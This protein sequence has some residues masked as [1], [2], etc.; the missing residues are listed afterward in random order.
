MAKKIG[1]V[2]ALDGEKQ[3][4][5]GLSNAKQ[6][7]ARL[8]AELK[9]L[10]AE[11]EGS[12][13]SLEYLQKKQENLAAQTTSYTQKLEASKKGLGNAQSVQKKAAE[14]YEELTKALEKAK[15][16]Q[17]AMA[18]A[19]ETNTKESKQQAKEVEDLEKAVEKQ[20]L[21]VQKCEGKV[22]SW[23]R[24]V[25][26][27]ETDIE[28]NNRALQQ[29][30][31]YL[32]EASDATDKCAKSIDEFGN[33]AKDSADKS[34][35][36]AETVT[37][38]FTMAATGDILSS[39]KD[40]I[41]AVG[42][43]I[44]ETATDVSKA[45]AQLTSTTGAT[46]GAASKYKDVMDQIK[47]AGYG[48]SYTDVAS[49]MGTIIQNIG[50]L[51]E[52]DMTNITESAI[53]LRDAF[54]MDIQ[55]QMRAV[56]VM[57]QTMGVSATE[58]FDLIAAGAQ[59]G[60]N[61]SDELVDNLAE[62]GSLWGQAGFSASEAFAIME[63]GLNAG[64]YNLDKVNDFVKE[65]GIS[66]SDGRIEENI[67]SF[68]TQTQELFEQWQN[69]EASTSDVFYSIIGDLESMENQQDALTIASNTWS[70]LGEDNA[71]QVL[72][73]LNDVNEG[74]QNVQGTMDTLKETSFSD[75]ESA[76][77]RL[78]DALQSKFITPIAEVA[79]GVVADFAN[80]A[81][82]ALLGVD[83]SVDQY[84][85]D[86]M[87]TTAQLQT[88]IEA[89]KETFSTTLEEADRI[90]VLGSRLQ[91]LNDVEN[92]STVQKQEMA[93]IV[94]ELSKSIPELAD[95][96]SLENDKLNISNT[97]V[98][99]LTQNYTQLAAQQA[100]VAATQELVN[101][102][103]E[104]G[105][106]I[107]NAE[108]ELTKLEGKIEL[109]KEE[110]AYIL[111][112]Q[113]A[114]QND[115]Y[116]DY[117][118]EYLDIF[119]RAYESGI[120]TLDEF[121]EA[122]EKASKEPDSSWIPAIDAEISSLLSQTDELNGTIKTN[123]DI[124]D[125]ATEQQEA[126]SEQIEKEYGITTDLTGATEENSDAKDE[127]TSSTENSTEALQEEAAATEAATEAK[128]AQTA[129]MESVQEAYNTL[130]ESIRTSLQDKI[131]LFDL[132][133]T[134][135]GGEDQTVEQMTENLNS[136]IEAFTNYKDNLEA[137]KEHVGK[138]IAP[139]FMEYLESMGMDG[140]NTLEHILQ[141]FEDDEPEKV[142]ELSDKWME[143]MNLTDSIAKTSAANQTALDAALGELGSTDADFSTLRDSIA[144]AV[145]NASGEWEGLDESTKSAL[146]ETV[147]TAQ[148]MGIEIPE[149]LAEGISAGT[150]SPTEA[151]ALLN[152]AMQGRCEGLLSVA[153]SAGIQIP[154][155]IR[156]G[157]E[158]GGTSAIQAYNDLIALLAEQAGNAE[159]AGQ[160]AGAAQSAGYTTGVQEG[161]EGVATAAG[162]VAQAGA[163]AASD[164]KS[165][166]QTAG[167]T[168]ASEYAT[169]LSSGSGS[170]RTAA[171]TMAN[172]A[173]Q[174]VSSYVGSFNTIGYNIAQ[175]VERGISSGRSG[176]INA[177]VKLVTDAAAAAKKAGVIQSPSKLFRDE[178]GKWIAEGVAEGI[179]KNSKSAAKAASN[180]V[181]L[182][183]STASS[184]LSNYRKNHET[185]VEEEKYFWEQ[186]KSQATKGSSA[187]KK[188]VS[189][190][191]KL[192]NS[193]TLTNAFSSKIKKNFGVS[194]TEKDG[195]KKSSSDY[196]DEIV[197]AAEKALSKYQTLHATSTAQEIKYWQSVRKRLKT[198]TD[199][200]YEATEKIQKLTS[201][202]ADAADDAEEA[203][204]KA[205]KEKLKTQT[206]VID[207]LL[208]TYKT[209]YSMSNKA[210]MQYWDTARQLYKEGT[211]ERVEADKN[212]LSAKEAYEEELA[213]LQ[214]DYA[215]KKLDTE[216]EYADKIKDLEDDLT[217]TIKSRKTEILSAMGNFD[218]WD[219]EGYVADTMLYNLQTQVEGLNLWVQQLEE[220]GQKGLPDELMEELKEMGPDAA[221]NIYTLN[222]MTAEQLDQFVELWSEKTKLAGEQAEKE[223]QKLAEQTKKDIENL[224]KE[225]EEALKKLEADYKTSLS[226]V[227]TNISTVLQNLV[228]TSGSYGEEMVA[229][230][231]K[232]METAS[233]NAAASTGTTGG[234]S[235]N[236][237]GT[238][239]GTSS[240]VEAGISSELATGAVGNTASEKKLIKNIINSGKDHDKSISAKEKENHSNLWAYIVKKYG[241]SINNSGVKELGDVL[242]IST[243][244]TPT[245]KQRASILAALKKKGYASG[246]R[247]ILED[248]LAWISEGG[249]QEY[250]VRASDGAIMQNMLQGD[251]V[252]NPAASE[253]LY[254][255]ANNPDAF[256]AARVGIAKLNGITAESMQPVVNVDNREITQAINT[257]SGRMDAIASR[258]ENLQVLM[259]GDTVVGKLAPKMSKSF[260]ATATRTA[261]GSAR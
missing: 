102:K 145:E 10:S 195:S 7:S 65:F 92:R 83:N 160:E 84:Y 180:M 174:A 217:D 213:D 176:V 46:T 249:T 21:E 58:A 233:S 100:Y 124:V 51:N 127:N 167:E 26:D 191:N 9:K 197:T 29:N 22:S 219:A 154:E 251:K 37:K 242:G 250:I 187:Y 91:E 130:V 205:E 3:F 64:A 117:S 184:W 123:Q 220:L 16:A 109:L 258:M 56:N 98:A 200:W 212:Y 239:G 80:N 144:T 81:A 44:K 18:D 148:E 193:N 49:V 247:K 198:G 2:L 165:E 128:E 138:E 196:Y 255:F 5:Q 120:I 96:Y 209:Y 71:M 88:D 24:K 159:S 11:Y 221:A 116:T 95:A 89:T 15:A 74:Y 57:T 6:E 231:I 42:E 182:T 99:A 170:V 67:G 224:Q 108:D 8:Q 142:K 93:A 43:A 48:E 111:K 259:D 60:L 214:E 20:G 125:D 254:D 114:R 232:G 203:A 206:S 41:K 185:T 186:I 164:K 216:E 85:Q 47:A 23:S 38:G 25:A 106:Q 162:T 256:L 76:I 179:N 163:D 90:S 208:S 113:K 86:I 153:E 35:D 210:E 105:I 189:E 155:S 72:T 175:G 151:I 140:A 73:A 134:E 183:A 19:G 225:K 236:T 141:T 78:G 248:Q 34:S 54:G 33:A 61:R 260:A 121:N 77:G 14:R 181:K 152:S 149:G 177:A 36:F 101:E 1:I 75:V 66:L 17:K 40:A 27:A 39:A 104:A 107:S 135:D 62:Y 146:E 243:S 173:R 126:Y 12:A 69:G 215:D 143:A 59:R 30:E 82:D 4:T 211:D 53:T 158:A 13:N 147:N 201:E 245:D 28:K 87:D 199:A 237:G 192:D 115:D 31:K 228:K 253:N 207:K 119:K 188:A 222:N 168:A 32:K 97:E 261:R 129:A 190:I 50:E 235:G 172:G 136:Q 240:G 252:I 202:Q 132:F 68:S 246:T 178:V 257:L 204:E 70:S 171:A 94:N 112:V 150:T 227:E 169:G 103:I 229:S 166:Y 131:N 79:G 194:K 230:L 52:A 226:N 241:K 45:N 63:N 156:S 55:E 139:E 238:S 122:K 118:A 157:I 223:N 218:A 137:V 161:Q 244:K 234:A 133:E 110:E